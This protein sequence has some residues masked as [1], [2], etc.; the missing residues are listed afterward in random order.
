M[1]VMIKVKSKTIIIFSSRY[2]ESYMIKR[3]I[4][5]FIVVL[6]LHCIVSTL[7][8]KQQVNLR[9]TRGI[10]ELQRFVLNS[11]QPSTFTGYCDFEEFC[12]WS[13]NETAGFRITIAPAAK[14]LGPKTDA[15]NNKN[16][17][18]INLLKALVSNKKYKTFFSIKKFL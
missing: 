18:Y 7:C 13:W 17:E 16:G 12:D 4:L 10:K 3:N 5:L 9:E 8:D 11:V 14:D 6:T 2:Y 1:K 15:N